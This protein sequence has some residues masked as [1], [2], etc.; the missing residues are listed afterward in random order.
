MSM[1]T[2]ALSNFRFRLT[3]KLLFAVLTSTSV[4]ELLSVVQPEKRSVSFL[5]K[6]IRN[7][8]PTTGKHVVQPEKGSVSFLEKRVC[9]AVPTTGKHGGVS[10]CAQVTTR[11]LIA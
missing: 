6:R 2:A 4:V 9:N 10:R 8:V 5:E 1:S 7:A 11:C 3:C